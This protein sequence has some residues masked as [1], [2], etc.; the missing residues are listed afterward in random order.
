MEHGDCEHLRSR[1]TDEYQKCLKKRRVSPAFRAHFTDVDTTQHSNNLQRAPRGDGH[2]DQSRDGCDHLRGGDPAKYQEC[3]AKWRASPGFRAKFRDLDTTQHSNNLQR[4][5]ADGHRGV[6]GCD[7]LRGGDPAKYQECLA[8]WRASPGFRAKF[9]DM[10]TTQHSNNLQRAPA[11]RHRGGDGC[12]HLRGGD[13]RKHREC[14]ARWKALPGFRA[15][16][17][18]VD[19]TRHPNNPKRASADNHRD[20]CDHLRGD[21]PRHRDC[22]RR[23]RVS[24]GF[25]SQFTDKDTTQHSNVLK[26]KS[27]VP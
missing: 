26:R 3:L 19:T 2:S 8:R 13:P 17:T 16:F 11:D 22:L 10:D 14:L 23:W 7:H 4:T 12:D 20:G 18:D 27:R 9:T 6:D 24:S 21:P 15:K 1:D 25:R 5:P